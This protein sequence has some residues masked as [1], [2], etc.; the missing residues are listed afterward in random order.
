MLLYGAKSRA[1]AKNFMT[2][3][4]VAPVAARGA[5]GAGGGKGQQAPAGRRGSRGKAPGALLFGGDADGAACG[6][7]QVTHG[8]AV[9]DG[10]GVEA[11]V[12]LGGQVERHALGALRLDDDL[13]L[14]EDRVLELA[15][16]LVRLIGVVV[17]ADD[18]VARAA[19]GGSRLR[20]EEVHHA[21]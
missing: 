21:P 10:D 2:Q 20:G 16:H 1:S 14:A 17:P 4:S 13:V 5:P 6:E 18:D 11:Q 8:L 9:G 12:Q 7:A 15:D 3:S 19:V